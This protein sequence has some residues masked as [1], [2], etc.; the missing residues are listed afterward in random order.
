[1]ASLI[2]KALSESLI[3]IDFPNSESEIKLQSVLGNFG[4][5][6]QERKVF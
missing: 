2:E 4:S 3:I 1:M 5:N 6:K